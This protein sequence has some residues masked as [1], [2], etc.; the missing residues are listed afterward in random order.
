[1][2]K[3]LTRDIIHLTIK[4]ANCQI[5]YW[6]AP[7]QQLHNAKQ[8]AYWALRRSHYNVIVTKLTPIGTLPG[9][10]GVLCQ[11]ITDVSCP[12]DYTYKV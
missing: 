9:A 7:L 2:H 11:Y 10:Q 8:E 4:R 1:M 12:N 6:L 3:C 5:I